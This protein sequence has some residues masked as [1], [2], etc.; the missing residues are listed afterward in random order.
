VRLLV[1]GALASVT[2]AACA[3]QRAQTMPSA[4]SQVMPAQSSQRD[5]ITR[6]SQEIAAEGRT[7]GRGGDP[8]HP[9]SA[10]STTEC[11]RSMASTCTQSCALSD[12]ICD[13]AKK[14]CDL[15]RQL[16]GDAWAEQ[17]CADGSATCDQARA[18][19][20]ACS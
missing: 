12:T 11:A 14:I 2:I 13:N 1:I 19:C 20:C 17:R 9:M 15:A 7:L 8:A 18:A 4:A 3:S 6:L 5:E 10:A 16:P